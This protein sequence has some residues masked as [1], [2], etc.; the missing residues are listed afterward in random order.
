MMKTIS[1][2]TAFL[3]MTSCGGAPSEFCTLYTPVDLTRAGATAVVKADRPAA[4][5]I[6]VNEELHRAGCP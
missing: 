2:L 1:L 5:R 3:V 6:A 4:E